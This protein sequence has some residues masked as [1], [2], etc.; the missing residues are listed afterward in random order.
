MIASIIVAMVLS[1]IVCGSYVVKRIL[2]FTNRER[3]FYDIFAMIY[4]IK[5]LSISE[6]WQEVI[7]N[8]ATITVTRRLIEDE[9]IL[10]EEI[11]SLGVS[12]KNVCCYDFYYAEKKISIY[13]TIPNIHQKRAK[14][15]FQ[16]SF[17]CVIDSRKIKM[18]FYGTFDQK[19]FVVS[20]EAALQTL[21]LI[22][23]SEV[24][25]FKES[26]GKYA[27]LFNSLNENMKWLEH[28]KESLRRDYF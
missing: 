16:K 3:N 28:Q 1:F 2:L 25:R 22:L 5:K 26:Y 24:V 12:N 18:Y 13:L 20:P 15:I 17:K 11:I 23:E 14:L 8:T 21:F 10:N 27:E 7:E 6:I 9:E 19:I 4:F